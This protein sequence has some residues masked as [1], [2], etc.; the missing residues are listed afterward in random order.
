MNYDHILDDGWM[1]TPIVWS[2]MLSS[3]Y[4]ETCY[5]IHSQ[6]YKHLPR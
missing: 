2:D 6:K 5:L 4:L 1:I 3:L